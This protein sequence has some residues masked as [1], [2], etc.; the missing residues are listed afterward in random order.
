MSLL[1]LSFY[2]R[3]LNSHIHL[4][5]STCT[6]FC[7]RLT[8]KECLYFWV[9]FMFNHRTYSRLQRMWHT[10][11]H[12]SKTIP[13]A[14]AKLIETFILVLLIREHHMMWKIRSTVCE[15]CQFRWTIDNTKLSLLG[16]D[17][18]VT[19][20]HTLAHL[21]SFQTSAKDHGLLHSVLYHSF[22]FAFVE[23]Y[24]QC[25]CTVTTF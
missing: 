3:K 15:V 18:S 20:H 4:T 25:S 13:F 17:Q 23:S 1:A 6:L 21:T 9:F 8:L 7:L 16:S 19:K 2:P 12:D 22:L 24:R 14:S 10:E 11:R 5:N